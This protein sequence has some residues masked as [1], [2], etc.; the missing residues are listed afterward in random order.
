MEIKIQKVYEFFDSG[1]QAII[2]AQVVS[3][4]KKN[5]SFTARICGTKK[6]MKFNM[7]KVSKIR[8]MGATNCG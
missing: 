2:T 5:N 1:E 3:I 6:T 7:N 4:D 8:E